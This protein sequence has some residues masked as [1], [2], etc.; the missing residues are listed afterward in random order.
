MDEALE[1]TTWSPV[2]VSVV[3]SFRTA[4]GSPS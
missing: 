4:K 2:Y 1:G 3:D